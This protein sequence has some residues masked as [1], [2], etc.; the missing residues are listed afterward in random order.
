MR[1]IFLNFK[2]FSTFFLDKVII[3]AAL[4]LVALNLGRNC[5]F[6]KLK[7]KICVLFSMARFP[8]G[9]FCDQN[10]QV[11]NGHTTDSHIMFRT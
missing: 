11:Q 8:S 5:L 7:N 1:E 9:H 10:R 3:F 4:H 6:S 2:H